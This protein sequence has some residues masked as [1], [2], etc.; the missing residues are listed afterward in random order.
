MPRRNCDRPVAAPFEFAQHL[1]WRAALARRIPPES[2]GILPIIARANE[3]SLTCIAQRACVCPRR[4][5]PSH[6]LPVQLPVCSSKTLAPERLILAAAFAAVLGLSRRR[7]VSRR[8]RGRSGGSRGHG[9]CSG[10]GLCGGGCAQARACARHHSSQWFDAN[11]AGDS[12]PVTLVGRL[13]DD[14]ADVG[15]GVADHARC[16]RG[17]VGE[18]PGVTLRGGVRLTVVGTAIGGAGPT[19]AGGAHD[20]RACVAA[21]SDHLQQP[22]RGRRGASAVTPRDRAGRIGEERIACRGPRR[23][24]AAPGM[25][26][27]GPGVDATGHR[28]SRRC[29]RRALRR[30][31]DRDSDRRPQRTVRRGRAPPAGRRA[32]TTSSRSP[33]AT[34]RSSPRCWCLARGQ[35]A[36]R[37]ASRPRC[38]SPFCW[39][40][41]K[42][43]AARRRWAARS[44][45]R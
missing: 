12:D 45:R 10:G 43:P 28:P 39:A 34:S 22:G 14:G 36:C 40:T 19:L 18:R 38:P 29:A 5:P 16:R 15:Y 35:C 31:R 33:A 13:R 11:A 26:R 41:E 2:L 6:S 8:R 27:I 7:G 23:R 20:P 1:P 3:V 9:R 30:G 17:Q 24:M 37:I 21:A 25:G 42:S 32:L 4:L 44:R